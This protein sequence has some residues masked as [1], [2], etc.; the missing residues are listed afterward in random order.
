MSNS[1]QS[2]TRC[3]AVA[4]VLVALPSVAAAQ[5]L[6]SGLPPEANNP[7]VRAAAVACAGDI[8]KFCPTVQ[9]GGGR[10]VRCLVANRDGVSDACRAAILTAKSALG[11]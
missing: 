5:Q 8:Q 7:A 2:L 1:L 4:A 10:I 11:R 3:L 9:P 6:P